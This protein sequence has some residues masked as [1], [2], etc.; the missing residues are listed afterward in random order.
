VVVSNELLCVSSVLNLQPF[1]FAFSACVIVVY[2]GFMA[3][4]MTRSGNS[5]RYYHQIW[6][7]SKI[8]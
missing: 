3:A 8:L 7:P 2:E 5:H 6:V 4:H 1:L